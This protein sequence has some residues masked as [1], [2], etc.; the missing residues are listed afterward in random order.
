ML[1]LDG[2]QTWGLPCVHP[3]G[4]HGGRQAAAGSDLTCTPAAAVP[5]S[6]RCCTSAATPQLPAAAESTGPPAAE[7]WRLD[8][9]IGAFDAL[10][11]A[12]PDGADRGAANTNPRPLALD[13]ML[14]RDAAA[15]GVGLKPRGPQPPPSTPLTSAAAPV[16]SCEGCH[17]LAELLPN[18]P[19]LP[20]LDPS[21]DPLPEPAKHPSGLG[22]WSSKLTCRELT[23]QARHGA[24][25]TEAQQRH[26]EVQS[27]VPPHLPAHWFAAVHSCQ[28]RALHRCRFRCRHR[29]RCPDRCPH[30]CGRA[31]RC[32]A[33]AAPGCDHAVAHGTPTWRSGRQDESRDFLAVPRL[34]SSEYSK[35]TLP[36]SRG[37]R[38]IVAVSRRRAQWLG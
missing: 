11:D 15:A 26:T 23:L 19:D 38:N 35:S 3:A 31:C 17:L 5:P 33:G 37:I 22:S 2:L 9:I 32:T 18:G 36:S 10:P 24:W 6:E 13:S 28:P 12:V 20:S 16:A 7:S 8:G 14:P 21:P 25:T 34:H 27:G 29:R 1:C 4:H 30:C